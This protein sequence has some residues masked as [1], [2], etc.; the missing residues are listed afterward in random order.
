M[1]MARASTAALLGQ[2]AMFRGQ[3]GT[4]EALHRMLYDRCEA[5]R[6]L[7]RLTGE[8]A[9][10]SLAIVSGRARAAELADKCRRSGNPLIA[11]TEAEVLPVLSPT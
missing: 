3:A 10:R 4:T 1:I 6:L 2:N 9:R 7:G 5:V 11:C 8:Y